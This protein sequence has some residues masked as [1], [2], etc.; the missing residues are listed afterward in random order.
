MRR[1]SSQLPGHDWTLLIHEQFGHLP[2]DVR[3]TFIS[4]S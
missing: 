3:E 2:R 4:P 1:E